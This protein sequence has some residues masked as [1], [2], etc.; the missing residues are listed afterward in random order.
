LTL[1]K[2]TITVHAQVEVLHSSCIWKS[3][4]NFRLL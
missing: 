3:R 4:N 1:I 2:F